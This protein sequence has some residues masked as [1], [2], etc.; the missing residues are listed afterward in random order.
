MSELSQSDSDLLMR[1][2]E[3]PRYRLL[4]HR[5]GR[6]ERLLTAIILIAYFGY[7]L[8]IA[9]QKPLLS[10]PIA[11]GVTS[12]G[13]PLGVGIILM[14]IV[15]TAVYVRRANREFDKLLGEIRRDYAG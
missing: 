14:S 11:G 6:F 10:Q 1:I 9:F 15:L 2:A 8:L 13:I 4:L 7:V 12:F 3:D 5:R